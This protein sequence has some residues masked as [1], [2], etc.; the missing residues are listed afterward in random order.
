MRFVADSPWTIGDYYAEQEPH[1]THA[2]GAGLVK[3]LPLCQ[4]TVIE[5]SPQV[6]T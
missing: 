5:D 1:P 6:G 2:L 3:F 4:P